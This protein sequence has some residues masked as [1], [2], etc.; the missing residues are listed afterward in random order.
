MS[1]R[2]E[3]LRQALEATPDNH[4]VR[5]MLAEVLV[6]EGSTLEALVEFDRLFTGGALPPEALLAAGRIAFEA[7]QRTTG[8]RRSPTPPLRRAC[9]RTQRS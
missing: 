3:G 7:G 4:P 2:V 8:R 6:D 1:A 5:L 9:S